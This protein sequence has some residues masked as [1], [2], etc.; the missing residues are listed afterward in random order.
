MT[1]TI[2]ERPLDEQGRATQAVHPPASRLPLYLICAAAFIAGVIAFFAGGLPDGAHG[3]DIGRTAAYVLGY[4]VAGQLA[5]AVV[6]GLAATVAL[7]TTQG[8]KLKQR[9]GVEDFVW[10]FLSAIASGFAAVA[11]SAIVVAPAVT[12]AEI[13]PILE[14]HA[15]AMDRDARNFDREI[16][17]IGAGDT[18][19]GYNLASDP[20]YRQADAKLAKLRA[21]IARYDNRQNDLFADTRLKLVSAT[22]DPRQRQRLL[23][24]FETDAGRIRPLMAR[25]WTLQYRG[26]DDIASALDVLRESA[27]EWRGESYAFRR[28]EDRDRFQA[29]KDR[30]GAR[31]TELESVRQQ[32]TALGE[33]PPSR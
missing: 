21:V 13:R 2:K 23:A 12:R 6:V 20:G 32:L 28:Q 19:S 26:I 9:T 27:G 5:C 11:L 4:K 14:A 8:R 24:E 7:S 3:D 33:K 18:L 10:P 22:T 15:A 16:E 1:D 31:Q 29:I 25:Y 30:T 17:E